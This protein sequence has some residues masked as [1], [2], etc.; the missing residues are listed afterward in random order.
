MCMRM[1]NTI[2]G[3]GIALAIIAFA[4]PASPADLGV[5]GVKS[6]QTPLVI[7]AAG[8]VSNGVDPEGHYFH[9]GGYLNG[10]GYDNRM[11]APVYL[12]DGATVREIQAM[13]YDNTDS[14]GTIPNVGAGL[15]RVSFNDGTASD[16]AYTITSGHSSSPQVISDS[17]ISGATIDNDLYA[18]W[19]HLDF[20]SMSH[21]IY[22]VVVYYTE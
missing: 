2:T 5:R 13:V 14:C 16:M 1:S 11:V 6:W 19:V 9:A 3:A 18:Y 7:P 12:P 4:L 10:E 15:H 17:S 8:F 22:A 21:R 20:C